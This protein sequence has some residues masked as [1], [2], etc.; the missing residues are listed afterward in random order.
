M[1]KFTRARYYLSD[2]GIQEK[3]SQ[4]NITP[5][6]LQE[7][8]NVHFFETGSWTKR[9]GYIK[10]FD[11][12]VTGS[13]IITG[14]YE[15]IKR[16]GTKR[17]IISTDALYYGDQSA[18]SPTA[19]SGG[20]TFTV[21]SEGQ[22]FMSM[23]TFNNKVIGANGIEP[24][25]SWDITNPAASIAGMPI[26][27]IITTYQHFVFAGGNA[28]YPYRLYF[29]NDGDET[30]WT[31]T[32]YI[33]IGDL[34]SGIT[35]LAVLFGK[36]YIFTRRSMYELRG[37]D[38][39]TFQV[40]EVTTSTGCISYKSIVKVDNNLIFWSER[41]I[42]AFDGINVHYL[43]ETLSLTIA[44]LNYNRINYI[45]AEVY[46]A[47]N[48]V[49]FSVSTG[50]N[51][52]N[53][54]V[55]CM[56]YKPTVSESSYGI[57]NVYFGQTQNSVA[58]AV[59]TGMAFNCFGLERST[60]QLDRLY[61]GGYNGLIYLQD[62]GNNDDG[63]GIDF[64]IKTPPIDMGAPEEFKRF[65]YLWIFN[66]QEGSYNLG[67]SY[68]TDFGLGG[69]TTSVNLS[70][71]G[72]GSLWGTMKWGTGTWGASAVIPSRVGLKAKG[73]HMELTFSNSNADQPIV[74]K[75]F[76]VIGQLKNVG[77]R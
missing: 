11:N 4:F 33:D 77:R 60:T 6:E 63:A 27:P 20:L 37:Y 5:A 71:A 68:V 9:A 15:L 19:I 2:K 61:A 35:G 55:I 39:D 73:H 50:S 59:Y 74:I 66:K 56:T 67:I 28:T 18:A 43:S 48:Q 46:K 36:L 70:V 13:S 17:F 75:G 3:T 65:R 10:R 7:A 30:T 62:F 41:G 8:R 72:S 54:Q 53:N 21:G 1:I 47:K 31:G 22:N 57:S 32:D 24:A 12:A 23:I 26:A 69:T 25:W 40:D 14:L 44:G 42:Y 76:S 49:W 52:N 29:S 16:D 34:T 64:F 58:F 51:P 45:T 38:R